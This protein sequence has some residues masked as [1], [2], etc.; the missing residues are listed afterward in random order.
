M[1]N[2]SLLNSC[3]SNLKELDISGTYINEKF[4][5]YKHNIKLTKHNISIKHSKRRDNLS[6]FL[7]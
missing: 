6:F 4:Y 7:M 3:S 5:R 1:T 2:E